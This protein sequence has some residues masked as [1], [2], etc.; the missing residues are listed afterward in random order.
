MVAI[1]SS[2]F[3]LEPA[4]DAGGEPLVRF[5]FCKDERVLGDAVDRLIAARPA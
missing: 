3:Y 1:P 2:A 4:A 5:A